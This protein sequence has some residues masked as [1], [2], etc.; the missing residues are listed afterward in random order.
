MLSPN[1]LKLALTFTSVAIAPAT[2]TTCQTQSQPNPISGQ[3]PNTPTGTINGTVAIIPIPYSLARQIVPGQYRI[4]Q[5]AYASLLPNF[6]KDMYPALLQSEFDHDI[7]D[8]TLLKIPD[9]TRSSISFPFVDR[10]GDGYTSMTYG[11]Q[12]LISS[13]NVVAILGVV[14]YGYTVT[15]ATFQPPCDAYQCAGDAG[16]ATKSF[17]GYNATQLSTPLISHD[18]A[19]ACADESP[20]SLAL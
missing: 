4:L 5:N 8:G 19:A 13:T 7:R 1:L 12:I 14:A 3:Y 18:F 6:P 9:F 20:F 10:L 16:C 11:N 17:S 15:P 2:A